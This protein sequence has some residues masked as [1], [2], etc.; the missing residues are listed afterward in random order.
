M[1]AEPEA[2]EAVLHDDHCQTNEDGV[3]DAQLIV[4][5]KAVVAEDGAADD[6]LQQVVGKAHATEDAQVMKHLAHALRGVPC[7]DNS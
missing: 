4:A 2:C 1:A 6:G 5:G 7:R 3:G